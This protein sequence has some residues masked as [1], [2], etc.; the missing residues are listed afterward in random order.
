LFLLLGASLP[1]KCSPPL[2]T[3]TLT[4]EVTTATRRDVDD[5]NW[6]QCPLVYGPIEDPVGSPGNREAWTARIAAKD[7]DTRLFIAACLGYYGKV[8]QGIDESPFVIDTV[9]GRVRGT[10]SGSI[11]EDRS[12]AL[13][14]KPYFRLRLSITEGTGAYRDASGDLLWYHGCLAWDEEDVQEDPLYGAAV[15]KYDGDPMRLPPPACAN[16][17]SW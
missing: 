13:G 15:F 9:W 12:S 14:E 1:T 7:P 8:S 16:R 17:Q 10:A 5:A 6:P 2:S 3:D 4:G 11:D